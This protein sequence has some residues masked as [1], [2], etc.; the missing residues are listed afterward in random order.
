MQTLQ[1]FS[2]HR[3]TPLVS[4]VITS[5]NLPGNYLKECIDHILQLSLSPTEREIILI[6]DGSDICPLDELTE[7]RDSLIY[8]RLKN[9]GVSVA[10]N[11]GLRMA[12]GTYIQFVDGDD[13]LIQTPYEHCLDIARYNDPDIVV[14][15]HTRHDKG[16]KNEYVTPQAVSG[17]EYLR[18]NNLH[19]AAWTY[20]FRRAIIG[21]LRFTPGIVYGEDEEFTPQLF[22]RAEKVYKTAATAYFYRQRDGSVIGQKSPRDI[23]RRLSNIERVIYHL[24]SLLDTIPETER[25]ALN[26][27][28][29]QLTMDYLYNVIHLTHSRHHLETAIE[30]MRSHNLYPLPDKRYTYKYTLFRKMIQSAVGRHILLASIQ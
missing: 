7:Y 2:Q 6:D 3:Q 19:G 12:Q 28:I 24:Q 20:I 23:S 16:A 5:Y 11:Y 9:Q 27:R 17:T 26:R 25:S 29:A 8:L 10:R 22:L 4:F 15:G 18:N 1:D 21:N 30:R 13:Y 14:F